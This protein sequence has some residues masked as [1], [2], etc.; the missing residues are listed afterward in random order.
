[1]GTSCK[2]KKLVGD[3]EDHP[4]AYGDKLSDEFVLLNDLWIIP[5][6][7]GTS[8]KRYS[9]GKNSQDHPHAYGDKYHKWCIH[10]NPQGSS[11]RVWGQVWSD[12]NH[13]LRFRIIPTRMGTRKMLILCTSQITDHP[14][15]YG[16]KPTLLAVSKGKTGSSPRVWG[17][18][19]LL[20][21]IV[22]ITRIIPTRMGTSISGQR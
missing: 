20:S 12:V 2:T 21:C 8:S 4:H 16:D 22:S 1:M 19:H 15:A 5:T 10:R 18:A 13:S 11:P 6:R 14:H 7:M 17:Q 3:L 9:S